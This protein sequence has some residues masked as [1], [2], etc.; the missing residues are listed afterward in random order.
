MNLSSRESEISLL[1]LK[2]PNGLSIADLMKNIHVSRRTI[3]RELS[4]LEISLAHLAISLT[5]EDGN[6]RLI[7]SKENLEELN[8]VLIQPDKQTTITSVETR[9]S[10]LACKLLTVNE[11]VTIGS[12]AEEFEV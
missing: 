6:Y 3:Y 2:N 9:Q 8:S 11:I 10:A 1:L 5:K 4:S 12:L 7:G